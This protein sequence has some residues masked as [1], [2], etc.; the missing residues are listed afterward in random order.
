MSDRCY[1][2]GTP[3]GPDQLAHIAAKARGMNQHHRAMDFAYKVTGY[4]QDEVTYDLDK[5]AVF[6][7]HLDAELARLEKAQ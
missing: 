6:K 1:C 2:C 4:T 3:L 7:R 5:Y